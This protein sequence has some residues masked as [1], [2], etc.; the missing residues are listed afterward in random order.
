LAALV[1][2][3]GRQI[4]ELTTFFGRARDYEL[5][6][7]KKKIDTSGAAMSRS[8]ATPASPTDPTGLAD[9]HALAQWHRRLI[10]EAGGDSWFHDR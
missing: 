8:P 5:S 10:V 6:K 4:T 2:R 3:R 1:R 7:E 9:T